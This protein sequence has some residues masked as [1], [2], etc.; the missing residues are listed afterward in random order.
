MKKNQNTILLIGTDATCDLCGSTRNMGVDHDHRTD[1]IRGNLC[2]PCNQAIGQL[3]DSVD[4]LLKAI[5]YLTRPRVR[6]MYSDFVREKYAIK[7][8]KRR[9]SGEVSANYVYKPSD[10]PKVQRNHHNTKGG[11][12]D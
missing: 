3:G 5:D 4:G 11:D 12:S 2:G 8:H 6:G 7:E 10:R 9:N 1:E